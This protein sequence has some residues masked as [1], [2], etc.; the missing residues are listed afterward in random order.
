MAWSA[1]KSQSY[2]AAIQIEG[3]DRAGLLNDIT[4][5]LA[6]QKVNILSASATTAKDRVFKCRLTFESADP[7]HL[8][9][10][11]ASLRRVPGVFDVFRVRQ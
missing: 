3:L 2:L 4:H 7:K 9:H 1:D 8:S 6:E 10:L 5:V 11:L